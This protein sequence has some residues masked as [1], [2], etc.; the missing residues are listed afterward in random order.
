MEEAI[1]SL[2][3]GIP[4]AGAVMYVWIVSERTH[5]SEIKAWR[6]SAEKK[7]AYLR[8]MQEAI[9]KLTTE[10][11]KLT[12]IV[13]NYVIGNRKTPSTKQD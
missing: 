12:F 10:I 1:L 6:E 7:D 4:I 5:A 3:N 9:T 13:E 2:L 11:S 8:E